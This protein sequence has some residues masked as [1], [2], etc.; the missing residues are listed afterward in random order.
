M[1]N[2]PTS[3]V[4]II[5]IVAFV[6]IVIPFIV[7]GAFGLPTPCC[8]LSSAASLSFHGKDMFDQFPHRLA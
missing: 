6:M 8:W 4:G 3:V 1:G 2:I 7:V 5:G